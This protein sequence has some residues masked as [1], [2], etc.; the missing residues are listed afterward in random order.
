LQP[1]MIVR[2]VVFVVDFHAS[3]ISVE[4]C[5]RIIHHVNLFFDYGL[6]HTSRNL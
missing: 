2:D 6:N 1:L 3:P 5:N 4:L